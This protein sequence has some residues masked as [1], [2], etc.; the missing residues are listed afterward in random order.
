MAK[1]KITFRSENGLAPYFIVEG[2]IYHLIEEKDSFSSTG[3]TWS[4]TVKKIGF[5]KLMFKKPY[6]TLF[7]FLHRKYGSRIKIH[8]A[9]IY[10]YYDS[11]K[12]LYM[13]D[14]KSISVRYSDKYLYSDEK[15]AD[16]LEYAKKYIQ[17]KHFNTQLEF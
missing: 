6:K 16:V 5:R 10:S 13:C 1:N 3:Y 17:E 12:V 11:E 8:S 4:L 2:Y 7:N 9:G 14:D 15:Y